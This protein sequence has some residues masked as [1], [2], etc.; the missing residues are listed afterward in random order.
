MMWQVQAD[1]T[2]RDTTRT[3]SVRNQPYSPTRTPVFAPTYRFGDP[4][5]N[6]LSGYN[7]LLPDPSGLNLDLDIDTALNYTIYERIGDVNYRPPANV[8]FEEFKQYQERQQL[9]EYWRSRS[10]GLEGESAGGGRNLIPPIYIT[11]CGRH[12]ACA[13]ITGALLSAKLAR[14]RSRFA[15]L[16]TSGTHRGQRHTDSEPSPIEHRSRR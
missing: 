16:C 1:T 15:P 12:A 8:S 6:S 7:P 4:F 2:K 10:E 14:C 11:S 9:K 13:S 5:S 3:D